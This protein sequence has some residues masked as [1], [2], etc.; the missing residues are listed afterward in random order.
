MQPPQPKRQPG[1]LR[2]LLSLAV[3]AVLLGAA[4]WLVA[5][6]QTVMDYVAYYSYSPTPEIERLSNQ[7]GLSG[8]GK[9]LF[10]LAQPQLQDRTEFNRS[11]PSGDGRTAILGC[12]ADSRIYIYDVDHPDLS[13]IRTVTAAHEMLHVAYARLASDERERLHGLLQEEYLRLK[14]DPDIA[15]K[16]AFYDKTEPG[17]RYNELHAVLGTEID[18]LPADLEEYYK[19]YF[20]DR[21]RVVRLHQAYSQVFSDLQVKAERLS[22]QINRLSTSIETNSRLYNDRLRQLAADID[23]FNTRAQS[24][25]FASQSEFDTERSTLVARAD[26]LQSF[27]SAIQNDIKAYNRLQEELAAVAIQS[28]TL[29]RS[30]NS[31]LPPPPDI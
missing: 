2:R 5:N 29:N 20:D 23:N 11:C 30:I 17:E 1:P 10:Y 31:S 4:V 7:A 21:A 8:D 13:G 27:R 25:F 22:A 26:E 24:G 18:K 16:M 14:S 9:F 12:Y 6:R 28:D 15:K 19:H 3:V